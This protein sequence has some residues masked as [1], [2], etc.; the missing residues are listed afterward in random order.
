ML[1]K[2]PTAH[3]T[4][5]D[6]KVGTVLLRQESPCFD[7]PWDQVLFSVMP[8]CVCTCLHSPTVHLETDEWVSGGLFHVLALQ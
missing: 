6:P 7:S 1:R 4:H 2:H 8:P 3:R 5:D